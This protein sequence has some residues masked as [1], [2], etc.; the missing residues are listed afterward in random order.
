MRK[1]RE[2]MEQKENEPLKISLYDKGYGKDD[3]TVAAD[4][5]NFAKEDRYDVVLVDTAGRMQDNE[6]LMR[7]LAKVKLHSF[8]CWWS[9]SSHSDFFFFGNPTSPLLFIGQS[10]HCL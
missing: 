7:S 9:L 6:P 1:L 4:A 10:T 3:A 8:F 2:L 5:I